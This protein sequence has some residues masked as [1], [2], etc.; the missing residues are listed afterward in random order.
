ASFSFP[1]DA[2]NEISEEARDLIK[3]LICSANQ[4]LGRNGLSDFK[5]HPWFVGVN[6]DA[7]R[8]S[9]APY[10]PDVSSPTDTSNFDVDEN[11]LRS[12]DVVPPTANPVFSGLHLPFIGFTY[13]KGSILSK[14]GNF[15]AH[16]LKSPSN[17]FDDDT[18][19][20]PTSEGKN[21]DS[22]PDLR[23]LQDEVNTLTK[24]NGE[25]MRQLTSLDEELRDITNGARILETSE[26]EKTQK[27]R[28]LE[29]LVR[30]LKTERDEAQ[31]ELAE[32]NEKLR[33]QSKELQDA[34]SQRKLAMSEYTEISDKL[35]ELRQQKAKLSRQVRDK[36]EELESSLQKMDG[37]RSDVRRS[38]KLR[39]EL[40]MRNEDLLADIEK[41]KRLRER[42]EEQT[43]QFSVECEQLR[44]KTA[45]EIPI[46]DV[47]GEVRR[48]R[49]QLETAEVLSKELQYQQ[50]KYSSDISSLKEQLRQMEMNNSELE[51]QNSALR[52][53]LEYMRSETAVENDEVLSETRRAY[54]KEKNLL[55]D[56]NCRLSTELNKINNIMKKMEFE[57]RGL[58]TELEEYRSKK[59]ALSL[60]ESQI[61]EII[62]WVS[63]EKEARTYLQALT[64]KMTDDLESLKSNRTVN[65]NEK[66]WKNR[67]SQKLDKMELLTLQNTLSS[68]I[69]AKESIQS[70]LSSTRSEL[71]ALQKQLKEIH[72]EKDQMT[73]ELEKKDQHIKELS[74]KVE[75]VDRR[76]P[77]FLDQF[78]KESSL[79]PDT[80]GN[81]ENLITPATPPVT[82]QIEDSQ[83][84]SAPFNYLRP[85]NSE[86]IHKESG[87]D[88]RST[89]LS[90]SST[91]SLLRNRTHLFQVR[92]FPSPMKC[93]HCTSLM[94]GLCRQGVVC[95]GCN[96]YC[97]IQCREKAPSSCP[98]PL[99]HGKR[100]LGIDPTR[101]IGTAYEGYVR[102]PKPGGVK[103]GWQRQFVVVCDFK[104]FL[105][106]LIGTS[107][108]V[109]VSQVLDMRDECFEV[110]SV[111]DSDV[112]HAHRKDIP[113]IFR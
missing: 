111:R 50:S 51:K 20:C 66:N 18:E 2:A 73:R 9:A 87:S 90:V 103:K 31:R 107:A 72:F 56:E 36:E 89:M 37:L 113:C 94:V 108:N 105:Y 67:R 83:R 29:K 63:D 97:H 62:R 80:L 85:Y 48:L 11:D 81:N 84:S 68:E 30:S 15:V 93:G 99:E 26:A 10:V 28:E 54:E 8:D 57:R 4:R 40:E 95:E 14:N 92:T 71:I 110:A 27:V 17:N 12:S 24:K 38:D 60:W 16:T 91:G 65:S 45:G 76:S 39:R 88:G 101:G 13:T 33:L 22:S 49:M 47:D 19:P 58:D 78:F 25:L 53:R 21:G 42:S 6:W 104:L 23:R 55:V 69:S 1:S 34:L 3:Q 52:E 98:F 74:R 7:L 106:E 102:V 77:S 61:T 100:P 43:K 44:L 46:A 109:S 64:T 35:S 79:R 82:T 86:I 96:F 75:N 70:E 59:E 41:E 5:N 112:I 32:A